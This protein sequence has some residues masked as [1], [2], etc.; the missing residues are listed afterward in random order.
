MRTTAYKEQVKKVG[1]VFV[2]E[3]E[4]GKTPT[5]NQNGSEKVVEGLQETNLGNG[6]LCLA[7]L[8]KMGMSLLKFLKNDF[9]LIFL[10]FI[11]FE[12][13]RP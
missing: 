3:L 7:R 6:I 4:T 9:I 11:Y 1:G 10:M 12:R 13:E 5:Q 2:P 8:T